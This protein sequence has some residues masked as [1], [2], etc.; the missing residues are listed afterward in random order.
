MALNASSIAKLR[1]MPHTTHTDPIYVPQP[2]LKDDEVT[3]GRHRFTVD[4]SF[5]H[6]ARIFQVYDLHDHA[7][8]FR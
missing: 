6:S 3:M 5:I 4:I 7:Y 2:T 1:G 8:Q